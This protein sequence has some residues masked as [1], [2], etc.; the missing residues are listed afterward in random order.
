MELHQVLSDINRIASSNGGRSVVPNDEMVARRAI[1]RIMRHDSPE[2]ATALHHALSAKCDVL[3]ANRALY[4]QHDQTG[5]HLCTSVK[6]ILEQGVAHVARLI[7][8]ENRTS[9]VAA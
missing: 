9:T 7:E 3:D 6:R 5:A 4:Y 2:H 8:T 1:G